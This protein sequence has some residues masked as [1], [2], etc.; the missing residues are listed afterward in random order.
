[1]NGA[2]A[3]GF[4]LS[5][6]AGCVWAPHGGMLGGLV[7]ATM[8]VLVMLV[9]LRGGQKRQ[10]GALQK[11]WYAGLFAVSLGMGAGWATL[12]AGEPVRFEV[13]RPAGVAAGSPVL[14]EVEGLVVDT[15]EI[16]A[17]REGPFA[18]FAFGSPATRFELALDHA[19]TGAERVAVSGGLL[20]RLAEADAE[21]KR[22]QRVRLRGW[23]SGFEPP[24][25]PGEF[26]F[27]AF[28]QRRGWVGRLR[29]PRRAN[30]V[31][32]GAVENFW[33]WRWRDA[34]RDAAREALALGWP[35]REA[36][37][38]ALPL[39]ELLLLGETQGD[40]Q[41]TRRG[42]REAGLSHLLSI[43]GAHV[44]ALLLVVW[45]VAR[46]LA[47][48]PRWAGV[49]VL[50]VLGAYLLL[51]P[52]RVPIVR[53]GIMAALLAM[54][55]AT[56]RRLPA[57]TLWAAALWVTLVI[58]PGDVTQAGF[59]LSFVAVGA[60]IVGVPGL[61]RRWGGLGPGDAGFGLGGVTVKGPWDQV[62]NG[63][64]AARRMLAGALAVGT[65]AFLAAAPLVAR[66]FLMVN[67]W[68]LL[69]SVLAVPFLILVLVLGYVKMAVGL[70]MPGLGSGLASPLAMLADAVLGGVKMAQSLPGSA[71]WLR[72][73]PPW[74]WVLVAWGVA[75]CGVAWAG[76]SDELRVRWHTKRVGWVRWVLGFGAAGVIGFLVL[77]QT[78]GVGA[79]LRGDRQGV[80]PPAA[81]LSAVAVRDGSCF[82]LQSGEKTLVFDCGSQ[83]L[84]AVGRRVV[85]PALRRLG[86]NRIDVLVISHADLDHYNGVPELIDA[87]SVGEVWVSPDVPGDVKAFPDR[88]TSVVLKALV[89]ASIVPKVVQ[90]GHVATL[91][92][93]TLEVLWPPPAMDEAAMWEGN[94]GSVVLRATVAGRRFLL[95]GDIQEHATLALLENPEQLKADVADLPHHGGYIRQSAAW[96]DAVAPTWVLQSSGRG[97]FRNDK[98]APLL[99]DHPNIKR[100]ATA[101]EGF[102]QIQVGRDGAL[103]GWG[104]RLGRLGRENRESV[105]G[106]RDR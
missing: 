3:V 45:F 27:E 46:G 39:L 75:A 6:A 36:D 53:A 58:W 2:A 52:P 97:R 87:M 14:V 106:G 99:A 50:V 68:S 56:G 9:A 91:G 8:G 17:P 105:G 102:V 73:P 77:L 64:F 44:G 104:Y 80:G 78:D 38:G 89:D 29:V 57:A 42:F 51:V 82:V 25:N 103:A 76:R 28:A 4:A 22:G 94:D 81:T 98:W 33:L 55:S 37:D 23:W 67:P 32:R 83:Q 30:V 88:A 96:L 93:A 5:W 62:F 69:T 24:A 19:G 63:L 85:V 31:Y 86:I 43:S 13:Q 74:G 20:V 84:S 95:S 100:L 65:V 34:W 35:A 48:H 47:P 11:L 15:P 7:V 66:H 61:A 12:R 16:E 40:T 79:T 59:Q 10:A 72:S 101:R 49:A 54:G 70:L 60:L 90:R 92:D 41:A 71:W 21:L 26:D 1:M 18:P